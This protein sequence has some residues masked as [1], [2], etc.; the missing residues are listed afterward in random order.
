MSVLKVAT[1]MAHASRQYAAVLRYSIPVVNVP[2]INSGL[3]HA[4][5]TSFRCVSA[6]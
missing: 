6:L 5:A 4:V 1:V 3:L 2:A